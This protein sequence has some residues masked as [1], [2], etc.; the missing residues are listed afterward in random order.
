MSDIVSTFILDLP[1]DRFLALC[2][3][4]TDSA[5]EEGDVHFEEKLREFYE[6]FYKGREESRLYAVDNVEDLSNE[7]LYEFYFEKIPKF[8]T[9]LRRI[10]NKINPV[11][12]TRLYQCVGNN[13]RKSGCADDAEYDPN[14]MYLFAQRANKLIKILRHRS[15]KTGDNV[16][17]V[18][19][20]IRNP[21]EAIF[22]R[23]RYSAFYMI[24][25]STEDEVRKNRLLA[26][27]NVSKNDIENID[28]R[29][30]P[31]SLKGN[32]RFWSLDLPRCIEICDVHLYNPEERSHY[33]EMKRQLVKYL[34]LIMHPGLVTPS[35]DERCMHIAVNAKLSSGCLSRQVGAVVTDEFYSVK[36][37]GWNDVPKGQT[38]CNLRRVEDLINN[39]DEAAFSYFERENEEFLRKLKNVYGCDSDSDSISGIEFKGKPV[40]FCFKAIKNSVDGEKNQVHT[41]ALHAEENA[42]LQISK[43][44]GMSIS[45]G[46]LFT[47]ASPCEL[48]A[49]KAY[50]LEIGEI[51]F[52]DPY[53][54]ISRDHILRCGSKVPQMKLFAGAVGRAYQRLF[55]PVIPYKDELEVGL[56][57]NYVSDKE[58]NITLELEKLK[59]EN[60]QL[61]LDL[62]KSHVDQPS[63]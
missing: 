39:E 11:F 50:Q 29:E 6:P 32:D 31:K 37:I 22:F 42:F 23:D 54:G 53:P 62:A 4:V 36:S 25:V 1:F 13:V 38:P 30:N 12:Y 3:S 60:D 63:D 16:C 17:V 35:S 2:R 41:R 26:Q 59:K 15:R 58:K 46:R 56:N 52:I 5:N 10:I 34:S 8:S 33:K 49:K 55:E 47:T 24:S 27:D 45:G 61:R 28:K 21:Y 57:L 19:D 43:H 7:D 20:A 48:C 40:S 14:K 51:I 44:G 9:K 18:L